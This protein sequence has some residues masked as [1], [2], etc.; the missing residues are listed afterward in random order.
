MKTFIGKEEP[1]SKNEQHGDKILKI[2]TGKQD[3]ADA[4]NYRY[5]YEP[6]PYH[7]LALLACREY[8]GK[9][10][11]LLD[12]GCGKGRAVFYLS[13]VTGCNAI[14]LEYNE[15]VL[16]SARENKVTAVSGKRTEFVHADAAEYPVPP[17][18][19]RCFFFNPFSVEIFRKAYAKILE[20]WYESPREILFFFYYISDEYLDYIYGYT[21]LQFREEIDCGAFFAGERSRERVMIFSLVQ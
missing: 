14:G 17:E 15:R 20:S 1:S 6:T 8:I 3:A 12:Y 7:V 10:N 4:D 18:V 2:H 13:Y 21:D 11:T 5:A 9:G 19:D 16:Q